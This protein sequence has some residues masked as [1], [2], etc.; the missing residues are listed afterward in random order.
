[1]RS[2]VPRML[3][4]I[5]PELTDAEPQFD[6][7]FRP[8]DDDY[9]YHVTSLPSAQAIA[10]NGFAKAPAKMFEHG[11][12]AAHSAGRVFFTERSGIG[13]WKERVEAMLEHRFDDPPPVAVVRVRRA[14][15]AGIMV[16]D[17]VGTTDS[18]YPSYYAVDERV[19]EQ[20]DALSEGD[21]APG[22]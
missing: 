11:A 10:A 9:L 5:R 15:L 4:D 22:M 7:E 3:A 1:M 19:D 20:C 21:L 16:A 6:G 8:K 17:A 14:D 12:Y 13:F 18:R 2:K